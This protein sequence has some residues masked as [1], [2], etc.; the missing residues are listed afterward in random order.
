MVVCQVYTSADLPNLHHAKR[1]SATCAP[2]RS[3]FLRGDGGSGQGKAYLEFG[4]LPREP[5]TLF[6]MQRRTLPGTAVLAVLRAPLKRT[7]LAAP[8]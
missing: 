2:L 8:C 1:L 3:L 6:V 4:Y 5:V 7:L